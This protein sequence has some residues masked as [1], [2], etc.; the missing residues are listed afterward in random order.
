MSV[1]LAF[2]RR[3]DDEEDGKSPETFETLDDLGLF[4]YHSCGNICDFRGSGRDSRAEPRCCHPLGESID[5]C[6]VWR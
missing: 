3:C 4:S 2:D 6:L 5:R 1:G